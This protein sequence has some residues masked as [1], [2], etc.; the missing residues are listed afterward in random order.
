MKECP[1]SGV[2]WHLSVS[3]EPRQL[4]RSKVTEALR[5]FENNTRTE[6]EGK[7][8]EEER[9]GEALLRWTLAT[10]VD[11][12]N[13]RDRELALAASLDPTNF[14]LKAYLKLIQ[15]DTDTFTMSDI[16]IN[17]NDMDEF[18]DNLDF[19]DGV[20]WNRFVEKEKLY[21]LPLK[22]SFELFIDSLK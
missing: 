19:T 1:K 6:S 13:I 20:N 9:K 22:R 10:L 5:R 17:I 8:N 15:E 7:G 16:N 21:F 18:V 2:L 12:K 14:D 11:D 4:R 3:L